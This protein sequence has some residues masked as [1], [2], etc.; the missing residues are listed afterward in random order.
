MRLIVL[1]AGMLSS[2]A[3]ATLAV[4][5]FQISMILMTLGVGRGFPRTGSAPSRGLLLVALDDLALVR[6]A[7]ARRRER[8]A[9]AFGMQ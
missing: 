3:L 9:P 1:S 8:E 6:R 4:A 2:I 7:G 5:L